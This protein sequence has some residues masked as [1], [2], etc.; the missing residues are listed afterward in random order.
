MRRIL[1]LV[2]ALATAAG[3]LGACGGSGV[4]VGSRLEDFITREGDV[5]PFDSAAVN[6]LVVGDWGRN[7]FFNQSDVARAMGRTG[8]EIQSQFTISTGDNF[9]VSGVESTSD[10]KWDRSFEDI[11]TARSLQSRWYSTLGNHDWQGSVQAQLDY[12]LQS[13]RWY[14]PERYY[15]ETL[16]VD[17][18]TEALF[19]FLDT[20]P[21]TYTEVQRRK[22]DE[23]IPWTPERQLAWL[24]ST[25]TA[26]RAAWKIVVGHHPIYVG[27]VSY[28][29]NP[30][31]IDLLPPI[32]ERHGVQAYFAGHDHNLQHL[33][34]KGSTV[35]Y[36]ISGAGSL[37]R[38][39][40]QTP[41]TL[42]ALRTPGF[43]AVSLT[44]HRMD[45]RALD[46]E[47][48][49]VYAAT[50]PLRRGRRLPLPFGLGDRMGTS[51]PAP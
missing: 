8:N 5:E 27:S 28:I 16:P 21:L 40:V 46:E 2:I 14:L 31:L 25:L 43:M 44:A 24:D 18:S 23:S 39:V 3:G 50:V 4:P 26:S 6:F 19:V 33:R 17:D 45:I 15:A 30:I 13:D 12:T 22:Y 48:T 49:L 47:N 37:T 35:D 51:N 41:H 29:D 1:L 9:Y 42:F 38:E 20:S 7:G 10:P 34:P 36:F 11:Y 32:F